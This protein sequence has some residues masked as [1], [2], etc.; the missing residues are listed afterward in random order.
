MEKEERGSSL[1]SGGAAGLM[2][3]GAE[4]AEAWLQ[5]VLTQLLHP[6]G[7]FCLVSQLC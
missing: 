1:T 7:W 2:G 3:G 6:I 4:W 5:L